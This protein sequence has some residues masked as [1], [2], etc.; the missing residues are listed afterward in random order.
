M[1]ISAVL[2]TENWENPF[3]HKERNQFNSLANYCQ[4]PK[5]SRNATQDT[6]NKINK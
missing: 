3:T 6:S 2:A 4:Q 5:Q 1:I